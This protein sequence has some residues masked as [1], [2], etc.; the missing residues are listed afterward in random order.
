MQNDGCRGHYTAYICPLFVTVAQALGDLMHM[1]LYISLSVTN[2]MSHVDSLVTNGKPIHYFTT[3]SL[4]YCNFN[5]ILITMNI[6][7]VIK[8]EILCAFVVR[9]NTYESEV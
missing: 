5:W 9:R 6:T 4:I 2:I 1:L 3:C 8:F 7:S